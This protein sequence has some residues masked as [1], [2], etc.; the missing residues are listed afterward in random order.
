M[1]APSV[2]ATKHAAF[3]IALAMTVGEAL[4]EP[5]AGQDLRLV[6]FTPWLTTKKGPNSAKGVIYF[7]RGWGESA[8]AGGSLDQFQLAPF[9]LNTFSE[10]G[11]DVVGAKYPNT[12]T[13]LFPAQLVSP[14]ARFVNRRVKELRTQGYKRVILVGHSW[15]AWVSMVSAQTKADVDAVVAM[16]PAVYG[17]KETS[18]GRPNSFFSKNASEFAKVVSAVRTPTVLALFAEDRFEPDGR[19]NSAEKQL[20]KNKV[21]H[22]IV[23][24]DP[25]FKGHLAGWLPI[26]DFAYG[27]CI[28]SFIEHPGPTE[29]NLPPLSNSDVRS[30]VSAKQVIDIDDKNVASAQ[31]LVGK[32]F[33]I[34]PLGR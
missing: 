30:I 25:A 3:L 10:N 24:R 20:S 28:R 31:P 2:R 27:N 14:A 21:A 16:A 17:P 6:E 29:C 32:K 19:G 5:R 26:F 4:A 7:I 18:A 13:N 34:Y 8:H 1:A 23:N 9:F 11:W 12:P 33:A 15:G 22:L